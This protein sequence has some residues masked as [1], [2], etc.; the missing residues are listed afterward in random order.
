MFIGKIKNRHRLK[1]KE[2]KD[3]QS[4]INKTFKYDFLNE[5]SMVETGDFEGIKIILVDDE[6]SFMF[7]EDKII[8]TLHGINK[9][10]PKENFVVVDMGA[11]KFIANGAD[12][13]AP[14]IVDA[15]K[16]INENDQVWICDERHHK[17][18]AVGIASMS[19]ERMISEEKGKAIKVV[20]YVGDEVWN[21][22]A[23]SL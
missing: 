9:Y 16:N 21:L 1:S 7:Y 14:G 18:L 19:G 17:P 3:I 10:K 8:F 20:H 12:V 11:I 4:Q 13:M 15:D 22:I 5:R 6:P 23:K 2:I